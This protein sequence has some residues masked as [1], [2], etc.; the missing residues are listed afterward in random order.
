VLAPIALPKTQSKAKQS[1]APWRIA[2]KNP[3]PNAHWLEPRIEPGAA[4]WIRQGLR[5]TRNTPNR[6]GPTSPVNQGIA[7]RGTPTNA[8][9]QNSTAAACNAGFRCNVGCPVVAL[10]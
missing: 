5:R 2:N 9:L 7:T 3:K 8:V 4:G 6:P 10:K 1:K